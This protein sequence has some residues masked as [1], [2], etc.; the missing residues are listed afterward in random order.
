MAHFLSP[1][2]DLY[3]SPVEVPAI[4][5]FTSSSVP[6]NF[7]SN[8]PKVLYI[9]ATAR[10]MLELPHGYQRKPRGTW[11]T[12]EEPSLNVCNLHRAGRQSWARK[13]TKRFQMN[14]PIR[15]CIL[16]SCNRTI[17]KTLKHP[18]RNLGYPLDLVWNVQGITAVNPEWQV[19]AVE[20]KDWGAQDVGVCRSAPCTGW[21]PLYS[22][23]DIS[24]N[25]G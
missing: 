25:F 6:R 12:N 24:V 13:N 18:W 22:Y 1:D 23:S 2:V 15:F 7:E 21:L 17:D 8:T 19:W 11:S 3:K 10:N 14:L 9:T 5:V 16:L 4:K 20:K